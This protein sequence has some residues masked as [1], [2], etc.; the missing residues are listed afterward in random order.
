MQRGIGQPAT[1]AIDDIRVE[2]AAGAAAPAAQLFDN[3][4]LQKM[5]LI[6]SADDWN[7]FTLTLYR[8]QL[9]SELYRPAT[10][11]YWSDRGTLLETVSNVG[12]RMRGNT[13]RTRPE[14][15]GA[16]GALKPTR[17]HINLKFSETF[18]GDESV[19]ACIDN[20]GMPA[21]VNNTNCLGRVISDVPTLPSNADRSFM[22]MDSVALKMNKDDPSYLREVLAQTVL[23]DHGAAAGRAAHVALELVITPSPTVT[24]MYGQSLPLT[25]KMGVYSMIEP[26]DKVFV[27]NLYGKN[28]Y[29]FKVSANNLSA[30]DDPACLDYRPHQTGTAPLAFCGAGVERIDP[31]SRADW[32]GAGHIADAAYVNSAI[33][34]NGGPAAQFIAYQPRLDLKTKKDEVVKARAELMKLIAVINSSPSMAQLEAVFDTDS[35]IRAQAVDIVIGAVD[36]YAR[37]AN[38]YYLFQ[39]P[40]SGKWSYLTYDYD[41]S[42]RDRHPVQWISGSLPP[43]DGVIASTIFAG[44]SQRWRDRAYNGP[45]VLYDLVFSDAANRAGLLAQVSSLRRT[46]LDWN[47][48]IKP[49]AI[50]WLARIEP[51]IALTTAAEAG[52]GDSLYRRSAALDNSYEGEFGASPDTIKQYIEKRSLALDAEAH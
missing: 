43:F 31:V 6:V 7:A 35:F 36:H 38:N 18:D 13:S 22:G 46:W 47:G 49:L 33:N 12:F 42:F 25:F 45:P 40:T 34:Q 41:F 27:K 21:S 2:C 29:L 32:L 9:N 1:A 30:G 23:R 20:Q 51:E 50:Q 14:S 8:S 17:F 44:S 52:F 24:S 16:A 28:G 26:I 5:R 39:D 48:R 11:E 19:Y 4:H 15:W 37:V 10:L 3:D